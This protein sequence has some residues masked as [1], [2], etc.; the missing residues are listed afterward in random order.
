MNIDPLEIENFARILLGNSDF[1]EPK[2]SVEV[3]QSS[4]ENKASSYVASYTRATSS[5]H[6]GVVY[7]SFNQFHPMT[8][9][10]TDAGRIARECC[11]EHPMISV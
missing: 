11:E 2:S 1:L 5:Y 4:G 7:D 9:S 8:T 6:Q 3:G 10:A